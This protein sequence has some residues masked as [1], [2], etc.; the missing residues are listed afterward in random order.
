M[1]RNMSLASDG[2]FPSTP[3]KQTG[4]TNFYSPGAERRGGKVT[5]K[6]T[7][8]KKEANSPVKDDEHGSFDDQLVLQGLAFNEHLVLVQIFCLFCIQCV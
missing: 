2:I 8:Q 5:P 7:S 4:G 3:K 1:S 6:R